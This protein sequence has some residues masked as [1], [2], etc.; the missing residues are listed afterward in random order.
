MFFGIKGP[1]TM[2]IIRQSISLLTIIVKCVLI[3]Y[4]LVINLHVCSYGR[5][6]VDISPFYTPR[7][8]Y[9]IAPYVHTLWHTQ[10]A[11]VCRKYNSAH[12]LVSSWFFILTVGMCKNTNGQ[13]LSLFF[14]QTQFIKLDSSILLNISTELSKYSFFHSERLRLKQMN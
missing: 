8:A 5:G 2:L 1:I 14:L 9:T 3:I 11:H 13:T 7:G 4:Y 10:C 12:T 6:C